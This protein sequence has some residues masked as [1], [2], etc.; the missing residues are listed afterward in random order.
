MPGLDLW[1]DFKEIW[2]DFVLGT[3]YTGM[4]LLCLAAI[5]LM[6]VVPCVIVVRLIECWK[7][8]SK[9]T[10]DQIELIESQSRAQ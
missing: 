1:S 7:E 8:R 5:I 4:G 10:V 3:V 9:K 2:H 6:L